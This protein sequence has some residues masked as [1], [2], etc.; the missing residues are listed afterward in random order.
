MLE[1]ISGV[2]SESTL[3]LENQLCFAL[4]EASRATIDIYRPLLD[5]MGVT[6]PQ[7]LVLLILWEQGVCSV[8]ELGQ[9][10]HLD[11]G[12]LSPLL[13]RLEAAGF[14]KRQRRTKDE[15]VVDISL[16]DKGY[17]LKDQALAIP[18]KFSCELD[19]SLEEYANLLASLK[20]LTRRLYAR[21]ATRYRS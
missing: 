7:Y 12:T 4:Y 17:A 10:L 5:A 8:K 19:I 18:E 14:I 13:K 2:E 11:S 21:Q 20:K 3:K 9:L 15:R 6:Y 16:S 1:E